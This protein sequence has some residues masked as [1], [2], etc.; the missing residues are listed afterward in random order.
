MYRTE[1]EVLDFVRENDVKFVRLAFCDIFGVQKNISILASELK[2]ALEMGIS[3]DASAIEGFGTAEKSDLYLFPDT[4]TLSILP[5]RPAHGRV[6]RFFCDIRHPDGSDFE[7]DCR[8]LLKRTAAKVRDEGYSCRIGSECEFYLFKT[9]EKG[10]PTSEPLDSGSYMDT[11]PTDKG[12]NVR[13]EICL[14]LEEMGI[15]V[16]SSHHEQ[17]PGQNEIDIKYSDPVSSADNVITYKFVVRTIAE[18]N[19]LYA[20]F[21]PKPLKNCAGSGMHINMSLSKIGACGMDKELEGSFV[22]GILE[23]IEE[24]TAFLNPTHESYERLGV[25]K[26]PK[27]V[28]WSPENRSQ[29]VRIPAAT[30]EYSRIEVRSPDCMAN[31]YIAYTLLLEAGLD[32]IKRGL[33][34]PEPLQINL[35]TAPESLL[36]EL[37]KLPESLSEALALAEKSEFVRSILN[38]KIID[39]YKYRI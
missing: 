5:W 14:T 22:A 36:S 18:R 37:K 26:A 7:L 1:S 24:I 11:A 16:E 6:I 27:Y 17:G 29:L 20:S 8:K 30:G 13:R 39:A 23:H 31:P 2:R 15:S 34:P 38:R 32:G 35:Y 9:G 21:Y 10:E 3:F 33:V 4:S 25:F 19:G 28:T 12:E